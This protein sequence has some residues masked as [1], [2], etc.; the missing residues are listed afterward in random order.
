MLALVMEGPVEELGNYF[1]LLQN[2][3]EY[4]EKSQVL[5][6][7]NMNNGFTGTLRYSYDNISLSSSQ[8]EKYFR[9]IL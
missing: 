7:S 8:N 9:Q 1:L 3:F 6:K 2:F 5:L 4:I